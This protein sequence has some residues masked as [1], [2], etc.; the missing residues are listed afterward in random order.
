MPSRSGKTFDAL[1]RIVQL[2][3]WMDF[4]FCVFYN[5]PARL[6]MAEINA[7]LPCSE[8]VFESRTWTQCFQELC[9]QPPKRRCTLSFA[10]R[11]ILSAAWDEKSSEMLIDLPTLSLFTLITGE[12]ATDWLPVESVL[13]GNLALNALAWT[14]QGFFLDALVHER[15]EVALARWKAAWDKHQSRL[16][17]DEFKR[18]GV[19][20]HSLEMWWLGNVLLQLAKQE[21]TA[22]ISTDAE[23]ASEH[24]GNCTRDIK[25]IIIRFSTG[26][27]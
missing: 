6:T 23:S 19:P 2:T 27:R 13:I 15:V 16:A 21:Q 12:Y 14:A 26:A 1:D 22:L 11:L 25:D 9:R 8:H 3:C 20:R 10:M 4:E 5:I 24:F 7:E 17:P 18:L